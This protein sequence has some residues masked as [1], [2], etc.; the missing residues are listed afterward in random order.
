MFNSC[1]WGMF[2]DIFR[3]SRFGLGQGTS[4]TEGDLRPT[5]AGLPERASSNGCRCVAVL[6]AADAVFGRHAESMAWS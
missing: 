5:F 6:A 4:K 2:L 3:V 1:F